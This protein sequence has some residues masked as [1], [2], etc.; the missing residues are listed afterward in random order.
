MTGKHIGLMLVGIALAV[1]F[2][3]VVVGRLSDEAIA[4]VVGA[5]CGI[6]ASIPVS[7]GLVIAANQSRQSEPAYPRAQRPSV[8]IVP[9]PAPMFRY[10]A[11]AY[12][13]PSPQAVAP[14]CKIIREKTDD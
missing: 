10:G 14:E 9:N 13:L 11:T 8:V 1:T 3:I 5:M 12:C 7:I 2:A 4:V 6:S